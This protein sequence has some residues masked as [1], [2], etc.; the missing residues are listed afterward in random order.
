MVLESNKNYAVLTGDVIRSSRLSTAQR[1]RV[2]AVLSSLVDS[3]KTLDEQID[4]RGPQVFRGDS[5]QVVMSEPQFALH[6]ALFLRAG[7]K[8][9]E[10]VDTRI[11]VGLGQVE[12]WNDDLGKA[13]GTAFRRSGA[14]FD[15]MK[16]QDT[17]ACRWQPSSTTDETHAEVAASAFFQAALH[18]VARLANE[19]ST[20]E[21][22][23]VFYTLQGET[24][25]RISKQW[26]EGVTTQQN[27]AN[28]LRRAGWAEINV[29]LKAFY[30]AVQ[31]N[32]I[33]L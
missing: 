23:A 28:T 3:F 32:Y 16:R 27:I 18:F 5:W 10:Q 30:S 7:L 19:W 17:L 2:M 25:K 31:N 29:F 26:P 8:S 20:K 4:S 22:L 15:A 12:E 14:A 6:A 13:D 33:R 1:E 21:A 9:Q 11:A 24:Q